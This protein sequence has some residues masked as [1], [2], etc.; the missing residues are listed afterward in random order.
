M[1]QQHT[2]TIYQAELE[3]LRSAVM[4]M[5]G[6]VESQ[7][8]QAVL[9]FSESDNALA[10]HVLAVEKEVN[11]EH[12]NIDHMCSQIIALRQPA[13]SDLRM[14]L[15][16]IRTVSDL[17]RIG[18]E[19]SKIAQMA[20]KSDPSR[21]GFLP[22]VHTIFQSA[23][24]A[25]TMLRQALDAFA[26]EDTSEVRQ[27]FATDMELDQHYSASVRQLITFMMEDPRTISAALDDLWVAKAIER[28]GDHAENIAENA[29]YIIEG[30]DVRY[31][32]HS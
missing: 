7:L 26:R 30:E 29:I 28:A 5:G 18:D 3:D 17:E 32:H 25:G 20:L 24:L 31:A 2:S 4:K 15:G 12:L 13:A 9:A 16:M 19:A 6:K 22:R 21:R 10:E 23:D 27:I 11:Q 1:S 8:R 14:L